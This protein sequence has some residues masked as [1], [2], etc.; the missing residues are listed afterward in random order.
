MFPFRKSSSRSHRRRI[1]FEHEDLAG[2]HVITSPDIVG[3]HVSGKTPEEAERAAV[4]IVDYLRRSDSDMGR[5]MAVDL[6]YA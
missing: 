1:R 3:F 6:E 2:F 5:L 4:T